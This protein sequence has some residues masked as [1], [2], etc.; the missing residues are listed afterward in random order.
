LSGNHQEIRKFRKDSAL[1]KTARLRPD[2]LAKSLATD[3][4][5]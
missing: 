1:E 2:L 5:R 4:H 3:E